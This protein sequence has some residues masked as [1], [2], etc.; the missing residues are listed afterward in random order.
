MDSSHRRKVLLMLALKTKK[1]PR[2][3]SRSIVSF[4]AILVDFDLEMKWFNCGQK[5]DRDVLECHSP[6]TML[7]KFLHD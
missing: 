5:T 2:L 4:H 1:G 6:F 7:I 3:P